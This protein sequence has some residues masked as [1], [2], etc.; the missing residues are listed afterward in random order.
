MDVIGD[1]DGSLTTALALCVQFSF[2]HPSTSDH[3]EDRFIS[4]MW[5]LRPIIFF[6]NV[7]ESQ[8]DKEES[9]H[10]HRV[11]RLGLPLKP[12]QQNLFCALF[13]AMYVTT[14]LGNCL[15]FIL[16]RLSPPH[17]HVFVSQ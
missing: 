10:Y 14:A 16:I 13:L 5:I 7:I 11:L 6:I 12:E 2:I 17:A 15:I 8:N 1:F 4:Y 9:N 3:M